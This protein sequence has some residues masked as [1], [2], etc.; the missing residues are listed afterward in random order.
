M[1]LRSNRLLV[2]VCGLAAAIAA[3]V[4]LA[5][6]SATGAGAAKTLQAKE[7]GL[8]QPAQTSLDPKAAEDQTKSLVVMV[9]GKFGDLQTTGAGIIVGRGPDRVY[10]ATANHVVR[11]GD[12][13][14]TQLEVMFRWL[15]GEWQAA[16]LTADFDQQLD[17]GVIS[18]ANATKLLQN[19]RLNTAR[20][21]PDVKRAQQVFPVGYAGGVQWF[22]RVTPD[23]ISDVTS[24]AVRF[25]TSLELQSGQSGGALVNASYEIVGVVKHYAT[26]VAVAVPMARVIEWLQQHSYPVFL[27][28]ASTT[29]TV[30]PPPGER[31]GG[32]GTETKPPATGRGEGGSTR[33]PVRAG[34]SDWPMAG[35]SESRTNYNDN[36][37]SLTAPL[38]LVSRFHIPGLMTTSL[39]FANGRLYASGTSEGDSRNQVVALDATGNRVWT[40]ALDSTGRP[41]AVSAFVDG[42]LVTSASRDASLYAVT[43]DTGRLVW[44]TSGPGDFTGRNL[45]ARG[46]TVYALSIDALTAFDARS[47]R[48]LWRTTVRP[49]I[50]SPVFYGALILVVERSDAGSVMTAIAPDGS[51]R[52]SLPLPFA[53]GADPSVSIVERSGQRGTLTAFISSGPELAALTI[54][55]ETPVWR[56]N[57]P[58]V[59]RGARPLLGV[60]YGLV[61]TRWAESNEGA[62]Y[63]FDAAG[64]R[65]LWRFGT[66]GSGP[67]GP[68]IANWV[69][70]V[71]SAQPAKVFAVSIRDGREVWSAPLP[72][73]PTGDPIVANGQLYVPLGSSVFVYGPARP[74]TRNP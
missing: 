47:G 27:R 65:S 2:H 66:G 57:V 42:L 6:S 25:E 53:V 41:G 69:A 44:R 54:S 1:N 24:D 19:L 52:R 71:T 9:R 34:A 63:A 11:Q 14:A 39:L 43:S 37:R 15:P 38:A 20:L 29:P 10:I 23:L 59:G 31:S 73:A 17:L 67:R 50:A 3:A 28:A 21:A 18:V 74:V 58:V 70:Y 8:S 36:E 49:S 7:P 30:P 64:G 13:D 5:G 33:D 56:T 12:K 45:L 60:G 22:S 4:S 68:A 61:I 55:S 46:Q 32:P 26:P 16:A 72:S 48:T 62:F 35:A 40:F 51:V